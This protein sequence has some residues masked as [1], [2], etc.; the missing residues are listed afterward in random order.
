[1]ETPRDGI[2]D[3]Y[4]DTFDRDTPATQ[5]YWS[6]IHN[7]AQELFEKRVEPGHNYAMTEVVRCASVNEQL[8]D[9][10]TAARFGGPEFLPETFAVSGARVIVGVG[11]HAKRTLPK[12][13][14]K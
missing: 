7:R 9:V 5:A 1:M 8:G 6:A 11:E 13:L 2:V 4:E 10:L 14:A 3:R 12:A